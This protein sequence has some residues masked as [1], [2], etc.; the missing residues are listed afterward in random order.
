LADIEKATTSVPMRNSDLYFMLRYHLNQTR[1]R[2][3]EAA[4]AAKAGRNG[5]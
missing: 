5:S 1:S 3:A 4:E 2:L